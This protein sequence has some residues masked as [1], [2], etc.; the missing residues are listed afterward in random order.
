MKLESDKA[1]AVVVLSTVPDL[2]LRG[3]HVRSS[4]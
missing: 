3:R 4:Q 2:L 1:V